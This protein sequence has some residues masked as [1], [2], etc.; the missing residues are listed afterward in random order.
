[1]P[2]TITATA[3]AT[4]PETAELEQ[5]FKRYMDVCCEVMRV[6]SD[7]FPYHQIWGAASKVLGESEVPV[8]VVDDRPKALYGLS[9]K[10]H[11]LEAHPIPQAEAPLRPWRLP[12]SY[13]KHVVDHPEEY[14]SHPAKLDWD[15]L[16]SRLGFSE[17]EDGQA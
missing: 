3:T 15:W 13:M 14:L 9:L 4:H 2:D 5:L 1:M 7:H 17:P 16:R 11:A 8:A 10:D 6:H 12:Y